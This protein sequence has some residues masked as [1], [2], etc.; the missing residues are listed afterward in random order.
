MA[1]VYYKGYKSIITL[2]SF[3]VFVEILVLENS[4]KMTDYHDTSQPTGF[5]TLLIIKTRDQF[6][7]ME[8]HVLKLSYK[9]EGATKKVY[10]FHSPVS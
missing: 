3:C 6:K 10:K 1:N 4:F 5:F 7:P 2:G 8:H 9:L